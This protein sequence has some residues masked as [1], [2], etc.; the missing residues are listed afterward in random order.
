MCQNKLTS[1]S[2]DEKIIQIKK[3]L[4]KPV[5]NIKKLQK[6]QLLETLPEQVIINYL[7]QL[8]RIREIIIK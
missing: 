6:S 2:N 1:L 8:N 3:I 4:M 5:I 7:D